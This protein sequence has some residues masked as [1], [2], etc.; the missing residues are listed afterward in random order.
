L[1][2]EG[3]AHQYDPAKVQKMA[4]L[5]Q[6]SLQVRSA[7]QKQLKIASSSSGSSGDK[8]I[9]A[10]AVETLFQRMAA[11]PV[12]LKEKAAFTKLVTEVQA[13]HKRCQELLAG[14]GCS[15]DELEAVKKEALRLNA[16]VKS[17]TPSVR[18]A[19][20]A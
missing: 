2:S 1:L 18:I 6:S 20:G 8:K 9:D 4:E 11:L 16:P 19:A 13:W 10:G 15:M 12:E 14:K 3:K 17:M 5:L 7:I